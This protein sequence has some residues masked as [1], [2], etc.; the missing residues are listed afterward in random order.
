M[1]SCPIF[2]KSQSFTAVISGLPLVF[3][4]RQPFEFENKYEFAVN[5]IHKIVAGA[6]N[7]TCNAESAFGK[8]KHEDARTTAFVPDYS[9]F[10]FPMPAAFST[11]AASAYGMTDFQPAQCRYRQNISRTFRR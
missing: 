7:Q 1:K 2:K 3:V 10:L 9:S 8:V 4:I 5:G 11:A 6:Q